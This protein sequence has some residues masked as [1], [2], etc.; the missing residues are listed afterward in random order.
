MKFSHLTSSFLIWETNSF[1]LSNLDCS[2]VLFKAKTV[3]YTHLKNTTEASEVPNLR[4]QAIID[5]FYPTD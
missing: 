4:G 2:D 1:K 3:V 5:R